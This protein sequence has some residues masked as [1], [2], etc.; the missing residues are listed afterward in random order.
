MNGRT[1]SS[2]HYSKIAF[3]FIRDYFQGSEH[4][5]TLV[6]E[7]RTFEL[8]LTNRITI[9]CFPSTQRSLRGW[10]IPVAVMDE[11]GFLSAGGRRTATLRFRRR[12]GAGCWRSS[13]R[14]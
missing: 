1:G 14:G 4:L 13:R 11:L 12:S 5:R 6:A 2:R 7:V 10:S 3:G 9:T 8:E